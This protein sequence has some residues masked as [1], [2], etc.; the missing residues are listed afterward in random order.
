MQER[1]ARARRER[2]DRT[3]AKQ[4]RY[5]KERKREGERESSGQKG[6]RARA[7]HKR[8]GMPAASVGGGSRRHAPVVHDGVAR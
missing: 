3:R 5:E 1:G 8:G 4:E 7:I 2:Y 6:A